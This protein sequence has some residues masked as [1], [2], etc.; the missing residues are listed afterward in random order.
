MAKSR[1]RRRQIDVTITSQNKIKTHKTQVTIKYEHYRL[2]QTLPTQER[3]AFT[4]TYL[5]IL[6]LEKDVTE[7]KFT[8]EKSIVI[9][10]I[11]YPELIKIILG[12]IAYAVDRDTYLGVYKHKVEEKKKRKKEKV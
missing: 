12:F 6:F 10:S 9:F 4:E 11:I 5:A 7:V 8:K 1:G 2:I 3:R